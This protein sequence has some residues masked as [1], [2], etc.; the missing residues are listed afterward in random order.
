V[1]QPI[2]Q[3]LAPTLALVPTAARPQQ[4]RPAVIHP[5]RDPFRPLISAKGAILAP[6]TIKLRH[7]SHRPTGWVAAS[8][9]PASTGS[10]SP[11]AHHHA[12]L[13]SS[14]TAAAGC[15][16]DG[17]QVRTGDSL[18]SISLRQLV[19]QRGYRSVTVAWHALYAANHATIGADPGYV[20]V[21]EH[22][23]LPPP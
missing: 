6:V 1:T 7:G 9:A 23:C 19:G 12:A 21:G 17:Y 16:A 18:W 4:S 10:R 11:P 22:L 14:T 2:A 8:P 15:P 20:T 5:P 3:P 13:T